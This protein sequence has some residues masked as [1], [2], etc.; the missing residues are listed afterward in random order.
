MMSLSDIKS[1]SLGKDPAM[2]LIVQYNQHQANVW[3]KISTLIRLQ[4]QAIR[5]NI[6][7]KIKNQSW[8]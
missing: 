7:S 8:R 4:V 3:I 5:A 2:Q 1:S 6:H